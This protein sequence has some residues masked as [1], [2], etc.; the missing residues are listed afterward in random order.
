[1]F[2]DQST[3]V[4]RKAK[5]ASRSSPVL[6]APSSLT[7]APE[8]D[9]ESSLSSVRRNNDPSAPHLNTYYSIASTIDE[10]AMGFFSTHY[11]VDTAYGPGNFAGYAID[12]N[13]SS[14]MKAVG[15]AA[16]ASTTHCRELIRE[17]RYLGER[18]SDGKFQGGSQEM[19]PKRAKD[20]ASS[21]RCS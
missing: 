9:T 6:S 21:I 17:V 8:Q 16:M 19:F 7:I 20:P 14:C 2:R 5:G 10:R 11:I 13:L 15:L 4:I 18:S 12:D 3:D 1:M